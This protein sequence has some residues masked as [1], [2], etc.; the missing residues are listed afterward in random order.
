MGST[1][2]MSDSDPE[3]ST[4]LV[5]GEPISQWRREE[6]NTL[7]TELLG[8]C[9][10]TIQARERQ[11]STIP[12]LSLIT[13]PQEDAHDMAATS[14]VSTVHNMFGSNMNASC[15][16]ERER[17]RQMQILMAMWSRRFVYQFLITE[18]VP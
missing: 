18:I 16:G 4:S 14:Q 1:L 17:A 6:I 13:A 11:A 9:L 2:I 3:P 10:L 15:F 12:E 5:A 7:P 8:Q